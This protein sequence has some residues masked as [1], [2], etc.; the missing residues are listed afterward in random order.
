MT[1]YCYSLLD[2][3]RPVRGEEAAVESHLTRC[4]RCR[5]ARARATLADVEHLEALADQAAL[6][7]QRPFQDER[8]FDRPVRYPPP[9]PDRVRTGDLWEVIGGGMTRAV[10]GIV[11]AYPSATA[12][13]AVATTGEVEQVGPGD[14]QVNATARG[15]ATQY[16]LLLCTWATVTV[17]ER[18][19][20]RYLGRVPPA[21]REALA[22]AHPTMSLTGARVGDTEIGRPFL[23]RGDRRWNLRARVVE[24]LA[25]GFERG[26][27]GRAHVPAESLRRDEMLLPE[28]LLI[29]LEDARR[30]DRRVPTADELAELLAAFELNWTPPLKLALKRLLLPAAAAR[31]TEFALAAATTPEWW[32]DARGSEAGSPPPQLSLEDE[33]TQPKP[34][35]PAGL[36]EDYARA[37]ERALD[38]FER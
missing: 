30:T 19:F 38:R 22:T 24:T 25:V 36:V 17:H 18:Q 29:R 27:P 12:F 3:L 32:E 10:V 4:G 23:R 16:P 9:V 11:G 34:R 35:R 28:T 2:L 7:G 15:L 6:Q 8:W 31:P 26:R 14:L 13:L 5:R 37:V 21:T 33:P 1:D 20:G